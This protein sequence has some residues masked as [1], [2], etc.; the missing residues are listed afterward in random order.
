MEK[1]ECHYIKNGG[2]R[3]LHVD[4][5]LAVSGPNNFLNLLLYVER[6]PIPKRISISA[7]GPKGEGV[8]QEIDS[9]SGIVREV[10]ASLMLDIATA[11]EIRDLLSREIEE[12]EKLEA[13]DE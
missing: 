13:G 4:G 1:L 3:T 7:D 12:A 11:K 8:V 9:L 5:A 10:E 6:I 2:F